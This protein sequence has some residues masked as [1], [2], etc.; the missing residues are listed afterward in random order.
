[1]TVYPNRCRSCAALIRWEQTSTG[2]LAPISLATGESHFIDCPDRREWRRE[3][4]TKAQ[5][6][7]DSSQ[8]SLLD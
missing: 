6:T 5:P 4:P 8:P 7:P 3:P 2:K 1:M